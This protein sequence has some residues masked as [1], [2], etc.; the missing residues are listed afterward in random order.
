MCLCVSVCVCLSVSVSVSVYAFFVFFCLLFYYFVAQGAWGDVST[1][2]SRP[3]SSG[4][5]L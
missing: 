5:L 1:V 3:E 4:T 2:A